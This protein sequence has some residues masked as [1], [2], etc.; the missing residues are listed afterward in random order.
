MAVGQ[1]NFGHT[2]WALDP[3]ILTTQ[4]LTALPCYHSK[5]YCGP[6]QITQWSLNLATVWSSWKAPLDLLTLVSSTSWP[7]ALFDHGQA[8]TK[9]IWEW[10]PL[11]TCLACMRLVSQARCSWHVRAVPICRLHNSFMYSNSVQFSSFWFHNPG[12]AASPIQ[13]M[14]SCRSWAPC[15]HE[16]KFVILPLS[17]F[18]QVQVIH[19]MSVTIVL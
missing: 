18:H 8:V 6:L 3:L 19:H 1:N 17:Q 12:N 11:V 10:P 14:L 4:K 13:R 5:Y 2:I 7:L 15:K 16:L 9:G